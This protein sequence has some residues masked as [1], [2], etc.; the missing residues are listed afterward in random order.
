VYLL[1]I[2]QEVIALRKA[3]FK[4]DYNTPCVLKL[5]MIEKNLLYV[6]TLVLSPPTSGTEAASTGGA[7]SV[8]RRH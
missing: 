5:E 2:L 7:G 8:A 3:L 1:G 4:V 6:W